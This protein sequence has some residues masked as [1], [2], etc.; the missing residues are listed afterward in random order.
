MPRNQPGHR[1][2]KEGLSLERFGRDFQNSMKTRKGLGQA[3]VKNNR[4]GKMRTG[5]STPFTLRSYF[6]QQRRVGIDCSI[7][8]S[9][10]ISRLSIVDFSGVDKCFATDR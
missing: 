10:F 4:Q 1:D 6:L 7:N 3:A 8:P 2:G 5:A 9:L